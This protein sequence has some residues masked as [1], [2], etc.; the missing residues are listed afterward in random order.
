V[1][2]LPSG[3]LA[4]FLRGAPLEVEVDGARVALNADELEV[5]QA[6]TGDFVVQAEAGFTVA[7][8]PTVTSELRAEG[9]ARELV[10]RVQRLRKESGFDV[11]DRIRLGVSASRDE[12]AAFQNHR[13]FIMGETLSLEMEFSDQLSGAYTAVRQVSLEETEVTIGIARIV[14]NGAA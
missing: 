9:L 4:D 6:A 2:A 8:D 14:G 3:A 10:S 7:L 5:A 11:A 13:D 1:R 12:R